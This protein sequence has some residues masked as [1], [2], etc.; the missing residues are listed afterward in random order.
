MRRNFV[1]FII[2]AVATVLAY[3]QKTTLVVDNQT[4]G[5]LSSK[6]N[7]GDQLTLRN[8]KVTGYING[9]D[10][11]FILELNSNRSLQGVIDLQKANIVKGGTL[12]KF[13]YTVE[14]D[15]QIPYCALGGGKRFQKLILPESL[16]VTY[17]F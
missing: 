5:W 1:I 2:M 14:E 11:Q 16:E 17:Q 4:P 8:L 7:Y 3:A 10:L 6:I 12:K 13:P 15:N 9:T